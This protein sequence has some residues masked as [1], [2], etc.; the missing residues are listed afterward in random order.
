[1][2]WFKIRQIFIRKAVIWGNCWQFRSRW[3]GLST[4]Q[5]GVSIFISCIGLF[6]FAA[7]ITQ[8]RTKEIGIWQVLGS[9]ISQI[10]LVISKHY[11]ICVGIAILIG[12]PLSI[13]IMNSWL[14]KF[15]VQ[16]SSGL[17]VYVLP[18]IPILLL[19]LLTIS[20]HALRTVRQNPIK[21][22]RYDWYWGYF[23]QQN[24]KRTK[25]LYLHLPAEEIKSIGD[26]NAARR[27]WNDTVNIPAM[28]TNNTA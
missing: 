14:Q 13:M 7:L 20:F 1:M 27:L 21:S 18:G 11:L 23:H 24:L 25:T 2:D 19:T 26:N 17:V 6:G 8:K 28:I 9:T 12:I 5:S 22:L 10:I 15:A 16:F 4:I 3:I